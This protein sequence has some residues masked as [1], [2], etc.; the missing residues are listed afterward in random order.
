LGV[1]DPKNKRKS[2]TYLFIIV[3]NATYQISFLA[4]PLQN[5]HDIEVLQKTFAIFVHVAQHV[6]LPP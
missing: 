6:R 3:K 2:K 4:L 1:D 5:C